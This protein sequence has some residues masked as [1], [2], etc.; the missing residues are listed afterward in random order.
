MRKVVAP[1]TLDSIVRRDAKSLVVV[2]VV[3]QTGIME[4]EKEKA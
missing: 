1:N 4:G 3:E 2:L